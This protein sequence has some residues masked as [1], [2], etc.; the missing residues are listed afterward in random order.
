MTLYFGI[1]YLEELDGKK[2]F[3]NIKDS[4][5]HI[6]YDFKQELNYFSLSPGVENFENVTF[7]ILKWG[8]EHTLMPQ[9]HE[10]L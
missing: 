10:Q 6:L 9:L 5:I 7:C 4:Q 1:W 8:C 2:L 3:L